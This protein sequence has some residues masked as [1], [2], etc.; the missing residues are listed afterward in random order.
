RK[1]D[2]MVQLT[3]HFETVN[4]TVTNSYGVVADSSIAETAIVNATAPSP[5]IRLRITDAQGLDITGARLGDELYMR[6]E[7]DDDAVFGI[8]ARDLVAKSGKTD[9]QI[10]LIDSNGCPADTKIFPALH[11]VANSKTLMGKFD[12]FKFADDVVVRFQ[13]NVQFCLQ[14]C[15]PTDCGVSSGPG[16][17]ND[18]PSGKSFG[19]RR[20]RDIS[21]S[22]DL[23]AYYT[24]DE[25]S[26]PV[27]EDSTL[28]PDYPLQREIIVEGGVYAAAKSSANPSSRVHHSHCPVVSNGKYS[29]MVVIQHHPLIQR[30]GDRMVQLTCHFETVN[31]TVTNSY[32]VV[33][34]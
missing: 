25:S 11:R 24:G 18:N 22:D 10:T 8:F 34:E 31:R 5:N 32:G 1:G 21:Q 3:C 14:D 23:S 15:E 27:V 12:A 20:R 19:R 33:A 26:L 7:M 4:R 9:E 29:S 16:V 28:L 17:D 2:R 30:K 6:I 13:V